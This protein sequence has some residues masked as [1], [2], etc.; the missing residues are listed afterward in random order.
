MKW[1]V[2][3]ESDGKIKLTSKGG[4]KNAILPKGSYLTAENG[5]NKFILRVDDSR[6]TDPYRQ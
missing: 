2:L 4:V 6:Q 3:G 1:I 5:E